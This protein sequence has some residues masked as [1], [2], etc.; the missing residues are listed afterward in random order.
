MNGNASAQ[1]LGG[2]N[3]LVARCGATPGTI[4]V[5]V[6][7]EDAATLK[8][9]K[10][11]CGVLRMTAAEQ[12]LRFSWW[13]LGELYQPVVFAGAVTTA[14]RSRLI[15][16]A[17]NAASQP[18][19]SLCLWVNAWLPFRGKS[20]EGMLALVNLPSSRRRPAAVQD[21]LRLVAREGRLN[22]LMEERVLA[23]TPIAVPF[24]P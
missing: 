22:L 23:K 13:R 9:A 15:V 24:T 16:F 6:V 2:L 19:L 4:D 14:M 8:W 20:T 12:E 17:V 11:L 10:E 7:Y 5:Q 3:G 21:Y 1:R 18:P